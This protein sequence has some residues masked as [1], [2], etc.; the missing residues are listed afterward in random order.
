MRKGIGDIMFKYNDVFNDTSDRAEEDA[1]KFIMMMKS[2]ESSVINVK[3]GSV[4]IAVPVKYFPSSAN[5]EDGYME[6]F[7]TSLVNQLEKLKW[8]IVKIDTMYDA[9][10]HVTMAV[11]SSIMVA[12]P[13]EYELNNSDSNLYDNVLAKTLKADRWFPEL[14]DSEIEIP[15]TAY[16]YIIKDLESHL[17]RVD[18]N[19]VT[20]EAG[21]NFGAVCANALYA[22]YKNEFP[23]VAVEKDEFGNCRVTLM[24]YSSEKNGVQPYD[25]VSPYDFTLPYEIIDDSDELY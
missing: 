4:V 1:K 20:M 17:T 14:F 10:M 19:R 5:C 24:S 22:A 11:D 3:L 25:G 13:L 15:D 6:L 8:G 16:D 12:R 9:Y 21:V 23:L 18:D 7:Y 2:H